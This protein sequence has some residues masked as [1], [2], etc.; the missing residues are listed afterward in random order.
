M[1]LGI[2]I[3]DVLAVSA[4]ILT[5]ISA[6]YS[7]Y[8][9]IETRKAKTALREHLHARYRN[10]KIQ[11]LLSD[12]HGNALKREEVIALVLKQLEDLSPS[13]RKQ[14]LETFSSTMTARNAFVSKVLRES[15][16][17]KSASASR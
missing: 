7:A 14:L 4:G 16:E 17:L 5:T 10:E 1:D 15:A 6:C 3:I 11:S 8:R 12:L 13:Q 9:L 2:S